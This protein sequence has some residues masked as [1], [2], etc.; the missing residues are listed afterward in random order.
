MALLGRI[1]RA[2]GFGRS[3]KA[4][5]APKQSLIASTA[6]AANRL[7]DRA[8]LAG[9]KLLGKAQPAIRTIRSVSDFVMPKGRK[10]VQIGK[11]VAKF[12]RAAHARHEQRKSDKGIAK[13]TQHAEKALKSG[14]V[15]AALE[16]TKKVA[17]QKL[18]NR[19]AEANKTGDTRSALRHLQMAQRVQ[20]RGKLPGKKKPVEAKAAE[21][22][23]E[24][25]SAEAAKPHAPVTVH[26]HPPKAAE[27]TG[28]TQTGKRGGQFIEVGGKKQYISKG[29]AA[30]KRMLKKP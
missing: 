9:R 30:G 14:D 6:A 13:L 19:A 28:S 29:K 23:A 22:S 24:K 27:P 26:V 5:P 25:K 20:Q 16:A 3:Q 21:K 17:V 8:G 10:L 2:L 4:L 11:G 18:M 1:G 12:V 7:E 15:K